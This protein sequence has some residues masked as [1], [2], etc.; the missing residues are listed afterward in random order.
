MPLVR[1]APGLLQRTCACGQHTG[2]GGEC[3]ACRKKRE[4]G[5]QRAA[6]T[7]GPTSD[8]PPIVHAALR[9]PGRPLDA[10]ARAALEPRLGADFSHVRVHT[11]AQAAA[12]ARSV[13]A[14]AYTVGRDVVFGAGQYAPSTRAGQRLLAH[15]LTHVIQQGTAS[16][17]TA[18]LAVGPTDDAFER[19]ADSVAHHVTRAETSA[20]GQTTGRRA[21]QAVS[22]VQREPDPQA[23]TAEQMREAQLRSLATRPSLALR[24]WGRL[25]QADRDQVLWTMIS[26]YGAPFA[27]EFQKYAKG[28]KKPNLGPPGALKGFNYTP[29]Y[30][31]DHGYRHAYGELWVHPSGEEVMLLA[32]GKPGSEKPPA[33]EPVDMAKK[34][35]E[36]CFDTSDDEDGCRECCAETF[37]DVSSECRRYCEARCDNKL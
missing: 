32:P 24:Q 31:Y 15:E 28:D 6:I 3:E 10:A 4:Q 8:A 30:M 25:S 2:A 19:E 29:K 17:G 26:T 36:T 33:D 1:P 5:L 16:P 27:A 23:P 12:S 20:P 35:Q 21:G 11:D 14:L 13:N 37:P 18:P 9:S 22:S 34:C 7:A